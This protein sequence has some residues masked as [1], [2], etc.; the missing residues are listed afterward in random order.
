MLNTFYAC[1]S[2]SLL[3]IV[4]FAECVCYRCYVNFKQSYR[5]VTGEVFRFVVVLQL[6]YVVALLLSPTQYC[7]IINR[8]HGIVTEMHVLHSIR[9]F[10]KNE[11]IFIV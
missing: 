6:I 9:S 11:L 7:L 3:A 5:I 8:P 1:N 10:K 2:L 4:L